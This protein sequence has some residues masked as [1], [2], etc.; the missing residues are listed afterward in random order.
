MKT[1]VFHP[2]YMFAQSLFLLLE[3]SLSMTTNILIRFPL[4]I[5]F[6]SVYSLEQSEINKIMGLMATLDN[7]YDNQLIT[8]ADYVIETN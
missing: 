8:K 6:L 1:E 4:S 3:F 5:V 2:L 7:M